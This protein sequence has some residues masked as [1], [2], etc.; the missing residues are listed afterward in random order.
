[1]FGSLCYFWFWITQLWEETT[2]ENTAKQWKSLAPLLEK[3]RCSASKPVNIFNT[4]HFR[5]TWQMRI[6]IC[7]IGMKVLRC[8]KNFH[9]FRY[10][11]QSTKS[12]ALLHFHNVAFRKHLNIFVISFHSTSI[13]KIVR[14]NVYSI[15][16]I[17]PQ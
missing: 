11:F 10:Q 3:R 12:M 15:Y 7:I 5:I 13:T 16:A 6:Y 8:R 17:S 1:M 14:T 4:Q 2:I 9:Y